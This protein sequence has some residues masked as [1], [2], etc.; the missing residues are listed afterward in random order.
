MSLFER[1]GTTHFERN[2]AGEVTGV[3]RD[4]TSMEDNY[5]AKHQKKPSVFQKIGNAAKEHAERYAAQK[6][7]ERHAFGES[8]RQARIQRMKIEGRNVAYGRPAWSYPKPKH[9]HTSIK[10]HKHSGQRYAVVG[11]KAYPVAS[12]GHKK[13]KATKKGGNPWDVKFNFNIPGYKF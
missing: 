3:Y 2:E 9:H 4:T 6:R 12:H 5:Y 13:H 11:G 8:Y 7:A 1:K 10:K